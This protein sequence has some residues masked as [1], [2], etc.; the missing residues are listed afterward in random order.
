MVDSFRRRSSRRP[1]TVRL[2]M[3]TSLSCLDNSSSS[4]S[5]FDMPPVTSVLVEGPVLDRTDSLF[6]WLIMG[7]CLADG[8][9][10]GLSS[11]TPSTSVPM[12][13][14]F[15]FSSLAKYTAIVSP[16][17]M[18]AVRSSSKQTSPWV[19]TT[20]PLSREFLIILIG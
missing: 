20:N 6:S 7:I 4:V 19:I 5:F 18:D 12:S 2:K 14:L 15:A 1:G 11:K 9:T 13:I 17:R 8:F 10:F 3:M 16:L